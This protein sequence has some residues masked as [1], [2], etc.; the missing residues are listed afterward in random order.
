M[1]SI[2]TSRDTD[3]CLQVSAEALQQSGGAMRSTGTYMGCM[4][5]DYMSLQR[6]AYRMSSTGAVSLRPAWHLSW[7]YR[8]LICQEVSRCPQVYLP[9][10]MGVK[11]LLLPALRVLLWE[12]GMLVDLS[13]GIRT[14]AL[15][16]VMT[17]SGLPYQSG[18][19]AYAF[20]LQGP[21]NG[22][23][24]ACSSSLVA[25]HNARQ[26]DPSIH[27]CRPSSS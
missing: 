12:K 20:N 19:V 18:R 11:A 5:V 8:R 25:A 13:S 21:C 14:G 9:Y 3:A 27:V 23:D 1:P 6:E 10:S 26:G 22:I 24:T 2:Y 4:F 7:A 16:Q 15:L 17:G